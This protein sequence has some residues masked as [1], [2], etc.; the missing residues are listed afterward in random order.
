MSESDSTHL[1]RILAAKR[2]HLA[3][4]RSERLTDRRV[5][6]ALAG[7]APTRDFSEALRRGVAP[8]II[9][10][11]KRASPSAGVI[12]EGATVTG[13]VSS[14]GEAGASAVSVLADAHF[15]GSLDDIRQAAEV[16]IVP[17]LCKDFIIE[18]RQLLDAR[19][20]G[21]DAALLIA[22]ALPPPALEQ[23]ISFAHSI[24]LQVLC[25][26]HDEYEVDRAMAAGA[27]VVGVNA[28][29]LRTFEI[30]AELPMRL[31]RLVP[32]TFTYVAESGVGGVDDLLRLRDA[33]VDA[34]LIGTTLMRADD[35]AA[36]LRE[37]VDALS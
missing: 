22:A 16:S 21:A 24:D 8:R 31:R 19:R 11:F 6:D 12:R 17:I 28:R 9:A 4:Q 34:V 36:A 33:E 25:E 14:Y 37:L 18:R 7:L 30:D 15:E 27:R 23:L 35:P 2:A 1:D 26:A 20:A 13:I 29:D 3:E 5:E 10:E 32:R